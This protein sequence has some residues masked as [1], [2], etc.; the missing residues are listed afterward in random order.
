MKFKKDDLPKCAKSSNR[1]AHGEDVLVLGSTQ[2]ATSG[3]WNHPYTAIASVS[4]GTDGRS[5]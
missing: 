5:A 1:L 4:S 2:I 3:F